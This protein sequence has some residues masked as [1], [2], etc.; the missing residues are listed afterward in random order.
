MKILKNHKPSILWVTLLLFCVDCETE[1]A[2]NGSDE[3]SGVEL[4][5]NEVY[6][7][8]RMGVRLI[9]SYDL[10]SNSFKGTVENTTEVTN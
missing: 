8:V 2:A 10:S 6:H 3:E 4:A 1:K 7:R 9:M 5:L